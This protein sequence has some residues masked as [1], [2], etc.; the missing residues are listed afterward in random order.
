[1]MAVMLS[2]VDPGDEVILF[3]PFYEN[4]GPDAILSGATPKFVGCANPTGRLIPRSLRPPSNRTRAI[5][6]QL[7]E[8]SDRKVFSRATSCR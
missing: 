6:M 3:E 5:V 7:A 2:S 4:Y 1:M 8:Q